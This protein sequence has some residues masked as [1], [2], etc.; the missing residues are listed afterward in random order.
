M[1]RM[2]GVALYTRDDGY[3]AEFFRAL[4]PHAE[5]PKKKIALRVTNYY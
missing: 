2:S 1:A 4:F 5:L 3:P